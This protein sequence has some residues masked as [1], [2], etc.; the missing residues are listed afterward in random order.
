MQHV[1]DLLKQ[2]GPTLSIEIF[3]PKTAEGTE[4]LKTRLKTFRAFDPKFISVTYGAGGSTGFKTREL[5]STIQDDLQLP[6]MAHLTCVGQSRDEL[7]EILEGHKDAGIKNIMALR[8]D[9]PGGEGSFVIAKDGLSHGNELISLVAD[10][11]DF[12]IGCAGYPESHVESSSMK[13]DLEYLKKKIDAGATFIVTQFFLDNVYFYQFRDLVHE[14]G[15][16]VPIVPGLLPISNFNQ[17][18]KFANMCGCT[19]PAKVM[20]GLSGL[21]DEDQESF[22]LDHAEKQIEDLLRHQMDGIHL[23][24]LNKQ[25]AVERLAPVV[26]GVRP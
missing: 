3:P 13:S 11:G 8:G 1:E 18:T 14:L 12:S 24:A 21:S 4:R 10:V 7:K 23:Y 19:I 9:P 15:L 6:S 22:G 25:K 2:S 26:T 16:N 5:C 17:V 20:K